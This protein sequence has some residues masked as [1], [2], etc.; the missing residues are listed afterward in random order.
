MATS[1]FK[2]SLTSICLR[3]GQMALPQKM[4]KLFPQEGIV[5]AIDTVSNEEVELDFK[6]PRTVVGLADFYSRHKLRVNDKVEVKLE[7][8]N[9]YLLTPVKIARKT[10][11]SSPEALEKILDDL[12]KKEV[13]LSESEIRETFPQIPKS[14][15]LNLILKQDK[16]FMRYEGRW[17]PKKE[18]DDILQIE[19][20]EKVDQSM[21]VNSF[22][23]TPSSVKDKA[24]IPS[25]RSRSSQN[26][27]EQRLLGKEAKTEAKAE[28]LNNDPTKTS[29]T[30]GTIGTSLSP[31]AIPINEPIDTSRTL[32]LEEEKLPPKN[33]S[34]FSLPT[35]PTNKVTEE[36]NTSLHKHVREAFE[37]LGYKIKALS[38]NQLILKAD[39]GR[40]NYDSLA[41]LLPVKQSLDWAGLL[42]SR[43]EL[44]VKYLAI[45]GEHHDLLKLH[46]SIDLARATLWSWQG[47]EHLKDITKKVPISPIDLEPFFKSEGLFEEGIKSF[48]QMI[49]ARIAEQGIFS[50]ILSI[51]ANFKPPCVFL[52]DD[53]TL[54][55]EFPR[56]Q[57]AK[58]LDTLSQA[59]FQLLS[60]VADGEYNMRSTISDALLNF[61]EYS[62]SVRDRLHKQRNGRVRLQSHSSSSKSQVSS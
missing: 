5:K 8:D 7:E 4:L 3:S 19:S 32:V 52:L 25:T 12:L 34:K 55:A 42:N 14:V 2:Y 45:F 1:E 49:Y 57:L 44:G 17:R 29:F 58:I 62:L 33:Q 26:E 61:S 59:P 41:Y 6:P 56:E 9:G 28:A 21:I 31:H 10:D 27:E 30:K 15:D 39:L 37:K 48:E 38:P 23:A 36:D 24:I 11:Y 22:N 40:Y 43:R 53:I 51:L 16:R 47:I 50:H 20:S 54:D 60:K 35:N 13:P 46:S 18:E